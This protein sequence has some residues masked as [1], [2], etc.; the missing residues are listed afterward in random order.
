MM[1]RFPVAR[2]RT[3]AQFLRKSQAAATSIIKC[4]VLDNLF[5]RGALLKGRDGVRFDTETLA[6]TIAAG[7]HLRLLLAAESKERPMNSQ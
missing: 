2:M 1:R 7:S 4:Y 6:R 5:L 3:F